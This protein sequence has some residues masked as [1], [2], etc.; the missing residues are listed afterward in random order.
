MERAPEWGEQTLTFILLIE[1]WETVGR[2]HTE[3]SE[4]EQ[5]ALCSKQA[6]TSKHHDFC[7][8]D[9]GGLCISTPLM[10]WGNTR[11]R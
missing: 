3:V 7:V 9:L 6:F 1:C 8:L 2:K 4:V 5:T 11:C 10:P